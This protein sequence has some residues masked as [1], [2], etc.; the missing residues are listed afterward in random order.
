MGDCI[1]TIVSCDF[2]NLL[3]DSSIFMTFSPEWN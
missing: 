2:T 1:D 3:Q